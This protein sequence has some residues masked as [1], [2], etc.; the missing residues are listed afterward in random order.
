MKRKPRTLN[1][2]KMS[3][4]TGR[5]EID[6][7]DH[8]RTDR[9]TAALSIMVTVILALLGAA[10][11]YVLGYMRGLSDLTAARKRTEIK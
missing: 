9:V 2:E 4:R 1:F 7:M 8:E 11:I 10:G 3:Q 6:H 5:Y